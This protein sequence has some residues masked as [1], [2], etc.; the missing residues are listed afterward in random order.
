MYGT[1][2]FLKQI[3]VEIEELPNALKFYAAFD[4][5]A[6]LRNFDNVLSTTFLFK[7]KQNAGLE[8]TTIIRVSS[9]KLTIVDNPGA[10]KTEL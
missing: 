2:L 1:S 3:I 9:S 10:E 4:S 6:N 8:T 5:L 7:L